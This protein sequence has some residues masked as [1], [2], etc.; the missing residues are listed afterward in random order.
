LRRSEGAPSGHSCTSGSLFNIFRCYVVFVGGLW[1]FRD[2]P[3][4][5]PARFKGIL[6]TGWQGHEVYTKNTKK[7]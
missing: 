3:G 7:K 6:R 5:E 1:V 2:Q 4:L